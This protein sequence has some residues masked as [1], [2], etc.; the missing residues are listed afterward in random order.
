M[1]KKT[2]VLI[3][4]L[5]LLALLP[6]CSYKKKYGLKVETK[7][8]KGGLLGQDDKKGIDIEVLK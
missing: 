6:A 5:S 7:D 8:E 2:M 1:H 3:T 4:A